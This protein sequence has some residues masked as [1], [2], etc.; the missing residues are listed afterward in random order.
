MWPQAEHGHD[1]GAYDAQC[2]CNICRPQHGPRRAQFIHPCD[3]ITQRGQ[4]GRVPR[5]TTAA[6]PAAAKSAYAAER[7]RRRLYTPGQ[8]GG[9]GGALHVHREAHLTTKWKKKKERRERRTAVWDVSV[10]QQKVAQRSHG[11]PMHNGG[12]PWR[13]ENS[14]SRSAGRMSAQSGHDKYTVPMREAPLYKHQ[15]KRDC[16]QS[17]ARAAQQAGKR[18]GTPLYPS[19][20]EAAAAQARNRRMRLWRAPHAGVGYT[21]AQAR[22]R[23]TK[24]QARVYDADGEIGACRKWR[25]RSVAQ[26]TE[27]GR[28]PNVGSAAGWR[29]QFSTSKDSVS[30]NPGE[31]GKRGRWREGK[32]KARGK[33]GLGGT[34]RREGRGRPGTGRADEDGRRKKTRCDVGS[35]HIEC[36]NAAPTRQE[37][38]RSITNSD[39]SP[40]IS[41]ASCIDP[42]HSIIGKNFNPPFFAKEERANF[43]PQAICV[44]GESNP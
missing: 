3:Y 30:R 19:A 20:S 33:E 38:R 21:S 23:G 43:F 27:V 44:S 18:A 31:A 15:Q 16:H 25:W 29:P 6:Q 14:A 17:I 13:A 34:R 36:S 39:F 41:A 11:V 26:R 9:E 22:G 7:G 42:A 40:C 10:Y 4:A 8:G 2:F 1:K 12:G 28:P 5:Y 35:R 24:T 37:V 32:R